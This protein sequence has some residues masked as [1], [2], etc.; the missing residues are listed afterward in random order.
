MFLIV[1]EHLVTVFL[2]Q[3]SS[4]GLYGRDPLRILKFWKTILYTIWIKVLI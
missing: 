3:D 2:I 4:V 1:I